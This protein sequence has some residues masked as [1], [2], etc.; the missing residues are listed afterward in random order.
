MPPNHALS[1]IKLSSIP[2]QTTSEQHAEGQAVGLCLQPH[3]SVELGQLSR[4]RLC[5]ELEQV[6]LGQQVDF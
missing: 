1:K 2:S 4:P 6:T 5:L 3:F